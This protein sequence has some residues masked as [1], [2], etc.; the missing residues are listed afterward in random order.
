LGSN[1]GDFE[2][3]N[4][5]LEG[6]DYSQNFV[7]MLFQEH[8]FSP[9]LRTHVRVNQYEGG[10]SYFDGSSESSITFNTPSGDKRK[11][12]SLLTNG[13]RDVTADDNQRSRSFT[14]DL[15]S[16]HA[17]VNN[18]TP[19][20]QKSFKNRQISD[21]IG[22]ILKD[23]LGVSIPINIDAT[24]GL[25]GSDNQPIIL[26]QKSPLRHID[27]LRR[28]AISDKNYDGFLLFSG[29][30][31]SGGEEIFFKSI[32]DMLQQSSVMTLTNRTKFEIN[33][34]L[35]GMSMGN[36]IEMWYPK[37]TS[38]M[39]KTASF[40][41]GTTRYDINKGKA[42]VPRLQ[43]GKARQEFGSS[44]STNPGKLSGF[45]TDPYN[46]MPGTSNVI[47]E[48]SRRPDSHRAETAPYTEA[49]FADMMQ[50]FLTVKIPG[51]SNL[52]V[53]QIIDFD[54]RE[55]SDS[56]LNSDTKFSGKNL[57]S[58]ISHYIGP[59]SDQPRYVTYLDL[60]NVQTANKM[61]K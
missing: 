17:I 50:N 51:N 6:R 47:L 22:S 34:T 20:Y 11:Y 30:G 25:H 35:G 54:M 26:T 58:G 24:R 14:V 33:Q 3:G 44:T 36:V 53:G 55:N 56:F 5:T 59:A 13:I 61:V 8:I 42:D 7:S 9:F 32:Y 38:A 16:K 4:L 49:L 19:N 28:M 52:K 18:S 41:R 45:V 2:L 31:Q 12:S 46:K 29:I 21:V 10:Q 57:I 37:Q 39:E 48:D 15:V 43:S 40:S 60:I 27:D 23:G 1:P